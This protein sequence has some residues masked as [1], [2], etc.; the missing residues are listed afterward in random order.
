[1]AA[2]AVEAVMAAAEENVYGKVELTAASMEK[3][4]RP[5]AS[6]EEARMAGVLER[7]PSMQHTASLNTTWKLPQ[8]AMPMT[9]NA[10]A[11][12]IEGEVDSAGWFF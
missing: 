9:L 5:A 8:S 11:K 12:F 7:Y 6:T 1:M 3:P 4:S 10:T 2:E